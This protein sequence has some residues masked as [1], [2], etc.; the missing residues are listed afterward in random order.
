MN[1]F[2]ITLPSN[3]S[4][5]TFPNNTQANY[6]TLLSSPILLDGDYEVALAEIDYSTKIECN[7]GTLEL[8]SYISDIFDMCLSKKHVLD[9]SMKNRVS[10]QEFTKNLNILLNNFCLKSITNHIRV[11][12]FHSITTHKIDEMKKSS[13]LSFD[14]TSPMHIHLYKEYDRVESEVRIIDTKESTFSE[15]YLKNGGVFNETLNKW[16]FSND[17]FQDTIKIKYFRWIVNKDYS[18]DINIIKAVYNIDKYAIKF[19]SYHDLKLKW[20]GNISYFLFKQEEFFSVTSEIILNSQIIDMINYVCVYSDIIV[21]QYF[22]NIKAPI[23][24]MITI[25]PE[26]DQLVSNL[27]NLHYVRVRKNLISQINIELRDLAGKNI[28]FLNDFAFVVVKLHLRKV[29]IY[30]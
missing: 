23:L 28:K 11:F 8:S 3:A 16:I 12:Y 9:I 21:D 26:M 1:D 24:K 27:E 5:N 13:N 29:N 17:N 25:K 20:T 6:T 4:A 7:M 14:I 30:H 2:Y 10:A 15:T 22:G 18:N 19:Q